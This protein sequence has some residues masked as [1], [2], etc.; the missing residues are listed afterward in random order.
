M[1]SKNGEFCMNYNVYNYFIWLNIYLYNNIY[2]IIVSLSF[3]KQYLRQK[4]I[5]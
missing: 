2:N 4:H 5:I 1:M 3:I